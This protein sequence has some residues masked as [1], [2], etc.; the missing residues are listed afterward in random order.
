MLL[1]VEMDV[2]IS[3]NGTISTNVTIS[4]NSTISSNGWHPFDDFHLITQLLG[5]VYLRG[6][7]CESSRVLP[8]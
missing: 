6:A 5:A 4:L 7:L 8:L 3:S 1:S 2:T